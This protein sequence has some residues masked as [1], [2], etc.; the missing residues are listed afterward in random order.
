MLFANMETVDA[1]LETATV[2]VNRTGKSTVVMV[3]TFPNGYEVSESITGTDG[4]AFDCQETIESRLYERIRNKLFELENYVACL[5]K[6]KQDAEDAEQLVAIAAARAYY[7]E[8]GLVEEAREFEARIKEV[9]PQAEETQADIKGYMEFSILD[10]EGLPEHETSGDLDAEQA[11][12][13]F[14]DNGL[15]PE[16]CTL[17]AVPFSNSFVIVGPDAMTADDTAELL[18]ELDDFF[19]DN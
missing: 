5:E 17:E 19:S 15:V 10:S 14:I 11:R 2:D 1:K 7:A 13:Y 9:L 18:Q 16:G 4:L 12:Q 8:H 3:A 6:E